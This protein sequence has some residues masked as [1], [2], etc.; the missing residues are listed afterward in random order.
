MHGA[1]DGTAVRRAALLGLLLLGLAWAGGAAAQASPFE[2]T[3]RQGVPLDR[4]AAPAP[5][6]KV[7][8]QSRRELRAYPMQPPLIPHNVRGYQVDLFANKCLACH[9]RSRSAATGAPMVSVTHYMNRDGNFLAQVSP[10]R[11]FCLQCHVTQ[12]EAVPL[13]GND[14]RDL[15]S[16]IGVGSA[17]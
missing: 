2:A 8:K 15:R 16:L 13:V 1:V 10:R 9:A 11:Y 4:E 6:A 12:T 5:M 7:S 17:Q 3:L 14:F